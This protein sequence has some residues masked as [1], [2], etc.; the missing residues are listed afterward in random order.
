M[1][2]G[3]TDFTVNWLS[4]I[5]KVSKAKKGK[6]YKT[7]PWLCKKCGNVWQGETKRMIEYLSDFPKIGCSHRTCHECK[8]EK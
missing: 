7:E 5:E 4:D 1:I 3:R 6:Y 8:E 2:I